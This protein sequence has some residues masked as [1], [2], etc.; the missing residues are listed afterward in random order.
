MP[1]DPH[2]WSDVTDFWTPTLANGDFYCHNGKEF[3]PTG[4]N[5]HARRPVYKAYMSGN[6]KSVPAGGEGNVFVDL[7]N[8]NQATPNAD[9]GSLFGAFMDPFTDGNFG[10]QIRAGGGN[11]GSPGGLGLAI[12]YTSWPPNG[13]GGNVSA[14][15]GPA[16]GSSSSNYGMFQGLNSTVNN[17]CAF[18]ID[19][20]D[21]ASQRWGLFG[22]NGTPAGLNMGTGNHDG[23]GSV[24]RNH[25]HWVSAYPSN[26]FRVALP[27]PLTSWSDTS[28]LTAALLNGNTG[29]RDVLRYLNMPPLLRA[30]GANST[31]NLTLN[32]DN[33]IFSLNP[34]YDTYAGM[35]NS[36]YN[37]PRDG[38]YFV[39]GIVTCQGFSGEL[40]AGVKVNST[41]YYGPRANMPGSGQG[42]ASKTQIFSLRAGDTIQLYAKPSAAAVTSSQHPPKLIV[43]NVGN[44]GA[45]AVLPTAPDTRFRWTAGMFGDL[46]ALFNQHVANDLLFLTQRPY[47]L[48]Y[49][50]AAQ[51]GIPF[52]TTTA[53]LMDTVGG[54]VHG[55]GGDNYNGWDSGN[56]VY[57]SQADGWYMAV[58]ETFLTSSLPGGH[59]GAAFQ[60]TPSGAQPWDTYQRW[61]VSTSGTFFPGAAGVSY[62]YLRAGDTIQPGVHTTLTSGSTVKTGVGGSFNPHFEVVWL[63]E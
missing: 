59:V 14:G 33:Q 24:S 60:V 3:I 36:T 27:A 11:S 58:Q 61:N 37:V 9:T 39:H 20:L 4:V 1:V 49:Q 22:F 43:V 52:G 29:I 44:I 53:V 46:P 47:L 62:Y 38:L 35:P 7:N 31:Q 40:S 45:P 26:G 56:S 48:S 8:N 19:V 18:V 17:N 10:S 50:A 25:A 41:I 63:G 34:T 6:P 16:S 2:T 32:V 13:S 57:M 30:I 54:V 5:F 23:S 12:G 51:T 55:D 15:F 21:L 42:S 28:G